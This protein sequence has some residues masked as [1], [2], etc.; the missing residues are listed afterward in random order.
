MGIALVLLVVVGGKP[1][2]GFIFGRKYLDAFGLLQ[3]MTWS[4]VISTA[5]F[6]LESL[7][8]MVDRQRAAL[9]AQ[10]AAAVIYIALLYALTYWFG[11][12]GAGVAFLI[13]TALSGLFMLIPT[14]D[15][16]RNRTRYKQH[17][18]E[19]LAEI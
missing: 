14:I 6:P 3:I 17:P 11:L 18:H 7:L 10:T 5:V 15:S 2:I 4:L 12:T 16:Y 13:G 8:Y 1:V 19:D 9:A